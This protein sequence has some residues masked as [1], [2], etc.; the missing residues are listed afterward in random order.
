MSTKLSKTTTSTFHT[1]REVAW[2]LG[3]PEDDI[4]RSIRLGTIRTV[5]RRSGLAV[6]SSELAR[7]LGASVVR[8]GVA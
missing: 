6:S 8:G 1:I 7:R 3:V 4:S 2:I 5:R